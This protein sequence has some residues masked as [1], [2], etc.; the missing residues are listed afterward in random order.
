MSD[1]LLQPYTEPAKQF[2]EMLGVQG[3]IRNVIFQ[4]NA[5]PDTADIAFTLAKIRLGETYGPVFE[6]PI[7]SSQ[8]DHNPYVDI[9]ANSMATIERA[10]DVWALDLIASRI[11]PDIAQ[12]VVRKRIKERGI[13]D[14]GIETVV[15]N[16]EIYIA[17]G[18]FLSAVKERFQATESDVSIQLLEVKL[19]MYLPGYQGVFRS[20]KDDYISLSQPVESV[21]EM[22]DNLEDSCRRIATFLQF[23]FKPT[24][25]KDYDGQYKWVMDPPVDK[26]M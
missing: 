11:S 8:Y 12:N 19:S 18:A 7:L 25:R 17:D 4:E 24:L 21:D 16:P 26:Y 9:L 1:E 5:S 10:T 3:P 23:G 14:L 20:V 13:V 15:Q 22:L 6:K 2:A